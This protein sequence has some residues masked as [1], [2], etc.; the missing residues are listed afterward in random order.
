MQTA[1]QEPLG[2]LGAL[3]HSHL[4]VGSLET[5]RQTLLPASAAAGE[6]WGEVPSRKPGQSPG[7]GPCLWVGVLECS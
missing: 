5:G 4:G 2:G 3:G 1:K 6:G 7:A